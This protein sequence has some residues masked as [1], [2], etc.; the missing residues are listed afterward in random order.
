MRIWLEKK[1][2]VVREKC[3]VE[4]WDK[5]VWKAFT[6]CFA[7]SK[8]QFSGQKIDFPISTYATIVKF[9]IEFSCGENKVS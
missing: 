2:F 3:D 6:G 1:K 8:F 4:N 7:P 9:P 5:Y